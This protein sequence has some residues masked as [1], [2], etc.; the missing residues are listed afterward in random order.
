MTKE[1]SAESPLGSMQPFQRQLQHLVELARKPGFK[2]HAWSRAKELDAD[3]SGLF[4]GMA[5]ALEREMT[6]GL[7]TPT[8]RR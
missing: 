8:K 6:A 3:T 5:A 7:P 1:L 2:A 4:A